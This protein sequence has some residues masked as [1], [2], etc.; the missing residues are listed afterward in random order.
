MKPSLHSFLSIILVLLA[1]VQ[2]DVRA[3]TTT[4]TNPTSY[5]ETFLPDLLTE[6]AEDN[7]CYAPDWYNT[8][9][10]T[11]YGATL[12]WEEAYGANYYTVQWRYP[13]GTWYTLGGYCYNTWINLNDL[14]A[15]HDYEWRVRSHCGYGYSSS[16]CYPNYFTTHCN[17]CPAPYDTYSTDVTHNSA[18]LHWSEVWGAVDYIV[19]IKWPS[20]SWTSIPGS[21]CHDNWLTVNNLE[22]NT[23]YEWRVKAKCS[24]NTYSDWAYGWV[25]TDNYNYCHYPTWLHCYDISDYYATWSWENMY[26]DYYHVQWRYPGG[27]WYDL[28]GYCYNN[29]IY[30]NHLNPCTTYEWRVKS[31]C[32]SGGWSNW[33]YPYTFTTTCHSTC[34]VPGNLITK[35]IGDYAATFKWSPVYGASSYTV[36]MKNAWGSWADVPGGTTNGVWITVNGLSSCHSYE[37]RVRANC[38]YGSYSYWSKPKQFTTT[39]NYGCYPPQ[40]AYTNGITNGSATFHWGPVVGADYYIVEWRPSGGTW[41]EWQGGPITNTYLEV[42]GLQSTGT[43]EWRVKAHC[44]TGY[45]SPW[46]SE[47]YFTTQ[48]LSCGLPFFRYTTPITDSTATFNWSAVAGANNYTVQIRTINGLWVDV[49]GSPT[50]GTSITV[51]DLVPN[52]QYEWRMQVNCLNGGYSPWLSTIKFTTGGSNGCLTPAGLFADNLSLNGATLHWNAIAGAET[53]S[54]EIRVWPGG[55]WNPVIGSPVGSNSITVDGLSPFTSYEWHVRANCTGNLHSYWSGA[56]QFNTTNAPACNTPGGLSSGALTETTAT[57]SWSPVAN[58]I[59]YQVQTRLPNGVWVDHPGGGVTDTFLLA[60][61]FTQNT[62]YEWRV[63]TRC[64]ATTFSNWSAASSFTTIGGSSNNDNCVNAIL[65]TVESTCVSTFASNVDATASTP[66]PVGGCFSNGNKDVWF[67]FTMPDVQNPAVTIRTSAGSLGNAVME[68]YSG[69]D[70]NIL[71]IIACEDNNENGNGSS[72][73]V[74]NLTGTANATIW[75]RVWGYEGSTGTFTIC[76]FNGISFNYAV[77]PDDVNADAG[78]TI[79]EQEE[80]TQVIVEE[81][82]VAS[83]HVSPNPVSDE[84]TVL[85]QQTDAVRV[86]GIRVLD[87]TGKLVINQKVEPLI[88]NQYKTGVDMS[89]LIPGMYVLQV[90]TTQGLMAEKISVIR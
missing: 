59:G 84:L 16:W 64:D 56:S 66:P 34:A 44:Y 81:S 20:G 23:M 53:Y 54:V 79:V 60:T 1:L 15:C 29:W 25:T 35:D 12:Q 58:A 61:G 87:L 36:Q 83:L 74:I 8:Y 17:N 89:T 11:Q 72:M 37:W 78:E 82:G 5:S 26:A 7:P 88:G 27:S 19:Q 14:E 85:V 48:G 42:T 63:R 4:N 70:C 46:S 73:P 30:V 3:N 55:A 24:Y 40:W 41:L 90:Q 68:V 33:C 43:Y 67:K 39:C 2:A 18:K 31:Y 80:S 76:V 62:T 47:T 57:I 13:G 21:P 51:S 69:T 22:P 10:I 38:N 50:T 6:A 65:L 49:N 45:W 71:S 32:Y 52:T 28:G 86:T 9:N 77:T 75:V